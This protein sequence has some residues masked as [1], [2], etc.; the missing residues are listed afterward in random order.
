MIRHIIANAV[1]IGWRQLIF[2]LGIAAV[3]PLAAHAAHYELGTPFSMTCVG[4]LRSETGMEYHLEEDDS[5]LNSDTDHDRICQQATI[6]EKPGQA[7]L[8][9]TLK[10]ETVRRL[11]SVCSFGKLCE[12]SGQMNGLTH[13]VFFWEQIYSI[14][15]SSEIPQ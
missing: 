14:R 11:L 4:I 9:Y 3:L 12:I 6:A 8:R 13:D 5:H 1:V 10:G 15:G 2:S 7:A